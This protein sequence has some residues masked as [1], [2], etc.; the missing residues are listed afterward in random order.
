MLIGQIPQIRL[1][2]NLWVFALNVN[3]HHWKF[4]L[5]QP[6]KSA[7]S[8]MKMG[9]IAVVCHKVQKKRAGFCI[10]CEVLF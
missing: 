4:Q 3:E 10:S 7:H 8:L 2:V 6:A 1:V 9:S 5:A